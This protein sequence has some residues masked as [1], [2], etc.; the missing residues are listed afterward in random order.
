MVNSNA[1]NIAMYC[2][3]RLNVRLIYVWMVLQSGALILCHQLHLESGD[4]L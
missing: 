3:E 1:A 2:E 4:D